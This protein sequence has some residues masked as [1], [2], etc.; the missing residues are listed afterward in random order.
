MHDSTSNEAQSKVQAV[1]SSCDSAEA[2]IVLP[3][4]S[5][6]P[7]ALPGERSLVAIQKHT[8]KTKAKEPTGVKVTGKTC[9]EQPQQVRGPGCT[10]R[11]LLHHFTPERI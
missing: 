1:S 8:Q 4:T 3:G 7:V 2:L 6:A 5:R 11:N 9:M 10:Q